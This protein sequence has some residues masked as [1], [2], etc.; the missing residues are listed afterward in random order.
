MDVDPLIAVITHPCVGSP[1]TNIAKKINPYN[2]P[3]NL[4]FTAISIPL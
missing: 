4:K 3:S 1:P 2:E